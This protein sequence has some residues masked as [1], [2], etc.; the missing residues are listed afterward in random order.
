MIR[1]IIIDDEQPARDLIQAYLKDYADIQVIAECSNG[2][3]GFKAIQEHQPDLIFLDIQMPKI[4]GFEM[5]EL[6]ENPPA[7]IFSTA[8]DQ[9]ALQAFEKNACDY[10]LKPYN[11]KRMQ[12][13]LEKVRAKLKIEAPQDLDPLL[14]SYTEAQSDNINRL[15][16]K[17]GPNIKVIGLH[18]IKYIQADDDYMAI[19]TNDGKYLKQITMKRLEQQLPPA[20]FVRAHRSY[21]VAVEGISKL[22]QLDKESYQIRLKTEEAIPVSKSGYQKLKGVLQF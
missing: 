11:R 6:L 14:D 5:I 20:R 12:E 1:T 3:E 2:F 19:F 22:E 10:L 9:Y 21:I 8:F 15:V 18:D 7:I 13:A 17:N 4:T 16:V